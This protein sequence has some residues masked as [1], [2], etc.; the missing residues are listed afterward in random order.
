[1]AQWWYYDFINP[2]QALAKALIKQNY[3]GGLHYIKDIASTKVSMF[4]YKN[5]EKYIPDLTS[6]ILETIILFNYNLCFANIAGLGWILCKYTVAGTFNE[7]M[8]PTTVNLIAINGKSLGSA[9]YKD[10]IL[11]KDNALDIIPF[12]PMMEYIQKIDRVDD[13]VFRVLQVASLPL[14][15]VG[16]KKIAKQL[17]SVAEQLGNKNSY[18]VGDDT[19]TDAVK[20][21]P[22]DVNIEPTNI[23][24]LKTKYK[25][26]CL[27]SMGIYSVEEKRER[28]I[29][30]EVASQNDFTDT[31]YQDMK[32]QRER[33][34]DA[35]NKINGWDIVLEETYRKI[36]E[37]AAEE[38]KEMAEAVSEV[39]GDNNYVN[40][41]K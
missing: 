34:V 28:K 22:I 14:A 2:N 7:Y 17:Q 37:E 5:I 3:I 4:K 31:I 6:E 40:T 23:Y 13:A 39:K 33:F 38:Q 11:V 12:I 24:E 9:N 20:A 36:V 26:E 41:N 25:N 32:T 18:I 35:L 21:F 8:R 15:I 19:I 30:S 10:I 29:V 27:S 1:M 16:N